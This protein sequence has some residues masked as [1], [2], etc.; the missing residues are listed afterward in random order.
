MKPI[1][2]AVN[3]SCFFSA[4]PYK[5]YF[6]PPNLK[7]NILKTTD[8]SQL[9]II[10]ALYKH[11]YKNLYLGNDSIVEKIELVPFGNAWRKDGKIHCQ[12]GPEECKG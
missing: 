2:A 6:F 7:I 12:H 5:I 1:A 4:T 9:F 11:V 8:S 10:D 3:F